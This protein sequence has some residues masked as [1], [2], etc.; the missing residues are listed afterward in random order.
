[1]LLQTAA[2]YLLH[3]FAVYYTERLLFYNLPPEI[4]RFR[5]I[6]ALK[7]VA[8]SKIWWRKAEFVDKTMKGPFVAIALH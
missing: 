7:E 1:M 6:S 3:S 4:I 2:R 5:P 8:V